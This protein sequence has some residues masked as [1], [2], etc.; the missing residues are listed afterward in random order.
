MGVA[1]TLAGVGVTAWL[2]VGKPPVAV[3]AAV[4]A[5][6]GRSAVGLPA[7]VTTTGASV[8]GWPPPASPAAVAVAAGKATA[9][10][11]AG[12]TAPEAAAPDEDDGAGGW[13]ATARIKISARSDM[14]PKVA[15]RLNWNT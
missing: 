8:A 11:A 9:G 12:V 6:A 7:G 10:L 4:G 2:A 13:Q 1:C 15:S 5:G 14:R 3:T